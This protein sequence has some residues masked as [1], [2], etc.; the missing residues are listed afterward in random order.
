MH[1][2]MYREDWLY[3]RIDITAVVAGDRF[4]GHLLYRKTLHQNWGHVTFSGNCQSD[5]KV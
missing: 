2:M 1:I 3:S 5:D 4:L